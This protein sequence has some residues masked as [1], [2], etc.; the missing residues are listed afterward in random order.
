[1]T[2]HLV[3]AGPGDP[4][5]LTI[6]AARLLA[7]ADV[8][9]HDR[10]AHPDILAMAPATAEMIDVGKQPGRT[11]PQEL[12][13]ALL[14]HLG[15]QGLEVVRL[16]GGDP[17]VFGRGGE[18]AEALGSAGVPYDVVPGITSAIGAAAAAGVPVTHRNVSASFTVVTG[19]RVRDGSLNVAWEALAQV[20]GTIVI[21]MGV[22]ER[23]VI[24]ERLM[25]GGLSADTPVAAVRWGTCPDQHTTRTT[26]AG[27]A[28]ADIK[29]PS[30]IVIGAVAAFNL[31]SPPELQASTVTDTGTLHATSEIPGL[32]S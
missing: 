22:S 2:V 12:I 29:A 13:N 31:V 10:L 4:D 25:A 20:G 7:S 14:V 32:G 19:H 18:E 23:A 1:M 24:A 30:T 26:L 3:G 28:A 8:V 16:K 11:T 6:K 15:S 9:V 17:Y 27:L 5:L 21:L